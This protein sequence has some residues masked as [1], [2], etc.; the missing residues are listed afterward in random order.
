MALVVAAAACGGEAS[1]RGSTPP[2]DVEVPVTLNADSPFGYPPALYDQGVEGDVVLHLYVDAAG[3]LVT[4]STRVAETSSNRVLDSAALAGAAGLRFAPAIRRG[5]PVGAAFLQPVQ[6]RRPGTAPRVP[7]TAARDTATRRP[8]RP[9]T[10]QGETP[11]RGETPP[12]RP[13]RDST[14]AR[15]DTSRVY[16][17]KDR[18]RLQ[19][20]MRGRRVGLSIA[21]IRD[22]L[23]AYDEEGPAAQDAEALRI[24]HH[25]IEKLQAQRREV[26]SA[27]EE[28]K[29]A[30]AALE[31]RYPEAAKKLDS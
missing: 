29:Q 23:D 1:I 2:P 12:P 6:F 7:T 31:C 17:Y 4:E 28:L 8:P 24:H 18:A 5:M 10:T 20:I 19:L 25:R 22:I 9:A 16:S 3:R 21:E 14:P 30:C 13:P 26:E 11:G 15:R 27:I